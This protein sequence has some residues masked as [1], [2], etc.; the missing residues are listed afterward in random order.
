MNKRDYYEVL[1]VSKTATAEEVKKSYRKLAMKYHPD[2]NPGNK[3]AEENFKEAAEAYE[4]LSDDNK[5][6]QYDQV[7]HA[8]YQQMGG[9]GGYPGGMN[10]EDIFDSFGDIFGDMFGGGKHRA[11]KATGPEPKRGHDLAKEITI[12]LKDAFLGIKKEVNYY[13]FVTCDTCKGT[14]AQ[15]GSQPEM[16]STC[17]GAGQVQF[18]QGFFMY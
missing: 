17:Q 11:R 5:R 16:C 15:K 12:T 10:M 4:V 6:R 3:E 13:R 18:R 14:G 2:R 7:G 1:G 9:M 8:G